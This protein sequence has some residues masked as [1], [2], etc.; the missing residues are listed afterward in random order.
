MPVDCL[1]FFQ[2]R[3]YDNVYRLRHQAYMLEI[4]HI[5]PHI[6]LNLKSPKKVNINAPM[7]L[8]HVDEK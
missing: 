2:L 3:G 6:I 1:N 7:L 5:F 4:T 8:N